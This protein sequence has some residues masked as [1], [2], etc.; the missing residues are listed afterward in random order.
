MTSSAFRRAL[1]AALLGAALTLPAF[2]PA[3]AQ[4][5]AAAPAAQPA[6]SHL[7]A[8]RDVVEGSGIARSFAPMIPQFMSQ[9]SANVT[10]TRPELIPDMKAVMTQLQ[11]EFEKQAGEMIDTAARIIAGK[12]NETEL[13]DAAAFFKSASGKKYVESQPLFLDELVAAMQGWTEKLST[14]MMT[15]VRAEMK[16]KGHEI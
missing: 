2:A 7:A 12:M 11:P 16:K 8:A 9:I 6:A 3:A 14:E 1:R 15:R 5:P 4:Q 13:K 10:R